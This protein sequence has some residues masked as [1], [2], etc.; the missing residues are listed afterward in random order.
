MLDIR[1]IRENAAA[2]ETAMKNRNAKVD[3]S[4]VLE[5]DSRRRTIVSEVDLLKAERN[6]MSKSIGQM[7][8]A[9]GDPETIKT[10][11]REMGDTIATMDTELRT[12]DT[13]LRDQL[14]LIPNMPSETT[15]IGADETDNPVVRTWGV[16]KSFD[17]EP[18]PHWDL[19]LELGLFDL[20]RGAK[21]SGS[22]FPLFTGR[23]AKM[24]RAL[25]QFMLDLHTEEH[26]Y[27]E[28]S[29]PYMCNAAAMTGTGQ[30][31]KFAEDMYSVPLDGLYPIPTAEVPVTNIY[32]NE[33]IDWELP[34][35]HT[36]YSPCFRRE[37]GS[38][39]KDTRGLLRVHQ[40]DKVEMVKFTTPE[41]SAEEHE[42]L[43]ANA[44]TVLQKLGLHY[45]V[46]E[47][48]TG[49]LGFSAA[50]C[51][52]IELWAPAQNR[53]LEVSSCSNFHDYQARRA[54][55][56]YRGEDGKPAFVHTING[57]GVALPRLV[58][59]IM[60]NNQNADGS[61]NLPEVLWPYMGGLRKLACC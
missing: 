6:R 60:E 25:I 12:V 42:K 35:L 14:L 11:V 36:A 46:I 33:I 23:G 34:I 28:V 17:F 21:I 51:Y 20:E 19:G 56:R 32:S 37:A 49:D 8:Q 30:L 7:I 13:A 26:G 9:G 47:L 57:S 52:D 29:P 44:E 38:A 43:T 18:K 15:P 50:K 22:G 53:W 2:V 40:F 5:L 41:T 4:A 54:N 16:K 31:P 55:I 24:E 1:F 27:T 39:G 10:Q 48:C 45:R 58:I 61:I 59:A 3:V